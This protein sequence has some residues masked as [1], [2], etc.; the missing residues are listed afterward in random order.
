[1]KAR[2]TRYHRTRPRSLLKRRALCGARPKLR[3]SAQGDHGLSAFHVPR[4]QRDRA[5]PSRAAR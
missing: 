2:S 5:T 3:I 1:M 4:K